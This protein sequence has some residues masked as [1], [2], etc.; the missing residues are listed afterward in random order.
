MK[1]QPLLSP[2]AWL[3]SQ[4]LPTTLQKFSPC[5]Q[6]RHKPFCTPPAEA[7]HC[8]GH[9]QKLVLACKPAL[10]PLPR[11]HK[12]LLLLPPALLR[13]HFQVRDIS[14]HD[15]HRFFHLSTTSFSFPTELPI[16]ILLEMQL[17]SLNS[18]T[19][20]SDGLL[21]MN[22]NLTAFR[23]T[24]KHLLIYYTIFKCK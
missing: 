1:F 22:I 20:Q 4:I 14:A 21:P 8:L 10:C 13:F 2:S 6:K 9:L 18:F 11:W 12:W 3:L 23:E 15:S 5:H 19:Y 7:L 16:A 24:L 17:P